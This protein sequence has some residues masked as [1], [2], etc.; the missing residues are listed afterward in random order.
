MKKKLGLFLKTILFLVLLGSALMAA[1]LVTERKSSYIKNRAFFDEAKKDHLDVLLLG[2]SHVIDG[3]NPLVLYD[4]YGITSY[5]LGGHG[6]VM[7]ETY[8]TL[9]RALDYVKPDYVIVD[10]YMMEKNYQYL[11][12]MDEGASQDMIN[13][14]VKQLHLNMD[15]FPLSRLKIA[16]L[17]ELIQSREIKNQFLC[18]FIVYHDRWSEIDRNDFARL[19]DSGDT[20]KL[21]GAEMQYGVKTDVDVYEPCQE[22]EVLPEHTVGEEYLMKII[23]ECQRDGIGILLVYLPFSAETKDQITAN[24]V[25]LVADKYGVPYINMLKTEGV[26]D[27]AADLNDHGHL[28][29]QGAYKVTEYLGQYLNENADLPDHRGEEGYD[30][31][32]KLVK[33]SK[34]DLNNMIL[35]G[36]ELRLELSLLSNTGYNSIIYINTES[37]AL[38]DEGIRHLIA[39]ISGTSRIY[40]AAENKEAYI[41]V[42]DVGLGKKYE[43]V[44]GEVLE[45]FDTSMGSMT[46]IPVEKK[47][48]L[49]YPTADESINY[50]YDDEH[51]DKDIQILIYENK[52]DAPAAH[53]YYESQLREYQDQY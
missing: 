45:G 19:T 39:N 40:E 38:E 43:A 21:M 41:L 27:E 11:D 47:F 48:R 9:I 15:A 1:M 13:A 3:I 6:S 34:K 17:D 31:W 7:Q 53:L 2:S 8:W 50:L 18:D 10:C 12:V 52:G 30:N 24:T 49:L 4:D 22:G 5:N 23:D 42:N 14:S 26:I 16:A 33:R 36:S 25:Q 46:Y 51:T 32:D 35:D 44:G 20:N 37:P 28:N 29:V